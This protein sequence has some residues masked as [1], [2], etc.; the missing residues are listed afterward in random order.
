MHTF[1]HMLVSMFARFL[2]HVSN[3]STPITRHTSCDEEAD[4]H[5]DAHK[6]PCELRSRHEL[7]DLISVHACVHMGAPAKKPLCMRGCHRVCTCALSQTCRCV[8][9]CSCTCLC[10][11]AY[12]DEQQALKV[13]WTRSACATCMRVGTFTEEPASVTSSSEDQLIS[14]VCHPGVCT[15]VYITTPRYHAVQMC[16]AIHMC[17]PNSES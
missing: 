13:A 1:I 15:D 4:R 11:Y 9:S 16:V 2:M 8:R 17:L 5:D 14:Q 6:H 3:I 7:A 12:T 10:L